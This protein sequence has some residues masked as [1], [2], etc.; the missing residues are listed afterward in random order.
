[1]ETKNRCYT[2]VRIFG[3]FDPDVITGELHRQ[4]NCR[5]SSRSLLIKHFEK[6]AKEKGANKIMVEEIYDWN[7]DFF[8]KNG[9]KI[10]G[11]FP[12]LPKNHKYYVLDK[13]F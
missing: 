4:L 2:Y 7:A 10:A 8:L 3:D 6:K 13:D 1:M 12:D 11:T 5:C 9:Y